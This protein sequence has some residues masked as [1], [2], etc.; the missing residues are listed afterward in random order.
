MSG[1]QAQL[2]A[3]TTI[4]NTRRPSPGSVLRHHRVRVSVIDPATGDTGLTTHLRA[5]TRRA[6]PRQPESIQPLLPED[7]ADA[8]AWV[9]TCDRGSRSP[10]FSCALVT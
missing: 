9:V 3:F 10:R 4:Y 7:I 1:A 6:A 8:V 5:E 2:D